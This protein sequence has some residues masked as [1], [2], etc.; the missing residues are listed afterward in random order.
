MV[1]YVLARF[2]PDESQIMDETFERAA[3]ACLMIVE[4]GFTK[5]MNQYNTK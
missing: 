2:N 1:D 5:A 3:K 4:D